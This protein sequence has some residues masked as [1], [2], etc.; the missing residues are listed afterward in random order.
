MYLMPSLF[1]NNLFDDFF[2]DID[3]PVKRVQ[4]PQTTLMRTD[5]KEKMD[6][7]A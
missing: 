6:E 3:R 2:D 1:R 7:E 5:V 4:S